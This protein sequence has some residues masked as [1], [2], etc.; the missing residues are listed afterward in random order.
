M[1][2]IQFD[3]KWKDSWKYC[4]P[5][6]L[7]EI[8][9][10]T[11]ANTGYAY[12]YENRR[13]NTFSLIKSVS[14]QGD[15][16]LDVAAA[17]GNFTLALAELGYKVTW[18]DIREELVDYVKIKYEKGEV[19]YK[20]GNVFE[21]DFKKKF[22]IILA[23]E[24]IEHVAHPDEFACTMLVISPACFSASVLPWLLQE[25]TEITNS[26]IRAAKVTLIMLLFFD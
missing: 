22:D 19:D 11:K 1:K 8:Y 2:K 5:Y 12:A 4:Y 3:S 15:E 20:P 9:G 18:N 16:I 26:E 25:K 14:K 23:T 17:Q 6:D 21:V 13:K 10:E 7:L 24:I